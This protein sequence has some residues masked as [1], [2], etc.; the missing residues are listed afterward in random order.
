MCWR[1]DVRLSIGKSSDPQ[2]LLVVESEEYILAIPDFTHHA[3]DG[4]EN[5]II[6]ETKSIMSSNSYKSGALFKKVI[7]KLSGKVRWMVGIMFEQEL[8]H[9]EDWMQRKRSFEFKPHYEVTLKSPQYARAPPGEV[10]SVF[11]VSYNP[12]VY[13]ER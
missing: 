5:A 4:L 8:S 2:E 7:M 12:V 10:S 3:I 1:G 9:E 11:F 6:P 13:N